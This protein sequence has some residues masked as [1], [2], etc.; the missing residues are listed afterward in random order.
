MCQHTPGPRLTASRQDGDE[1]PG[2]S[3]AQYPTSQLGPAT[4]FLWVP[5]FRLSIYERDTS[6]AQVFREILQD[7]EVWERMLGARAPTSSSS[8]HVGE[9]IKDKGFDHAAC[10]VH[11]G[12]RPSASSRPPRGTGSAAQRAITVPVCRRRRRRRRIQSGSY[13]L[14]PLLRDRLTGSLQLK[15]RDI[16]RRMDELL[17]Y[18]RTSRPAGL[19]RGGGTPTRPAPRVPAPRPH[20]AYLVRLTTRCEQA[21]SAPPS[22]SLASCPDL[23]A[24]SAAPEQTHP[25]REPRLKA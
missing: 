23:L 15:L 4:S 20:R 21:R 5:A 2:R 14:A 7:L 9:Q 1:I 17:A 18:A 16:P 13:P 10:P 6:E 24:A 3:P 25:M 8:I 19:P 11:Q 22:P 12:R